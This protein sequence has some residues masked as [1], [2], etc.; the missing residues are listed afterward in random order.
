MTVGEHDA[1][2]ECGVA[3]GVHMWLMQR[4]SVAGRPAGGDL[5]VDTD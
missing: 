3:D 1:V 2:S 4:Q 5:T